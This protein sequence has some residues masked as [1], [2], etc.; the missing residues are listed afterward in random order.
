MPRVWSIGESRRRCQGPTTPPHRPWPASAFSPAWRTAVRPTVFA[1]EPHVALPCPGCPGPSH[2]TPWPSPGHDS[3]LQCPPVLCL[4]SRPK[5]H[6][7]QP[8]LEH[9]TRLFLRTLALT[10]PFLRLDPNVAFGG[11]L[12]RPPYLMP[13]ANRHPQWL[14]LLPCMAFLHFYL[15]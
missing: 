4:A 14:Y 9:G 11:G 2:L 15:L 5:M 8:H 1:C 10:V 6:P 12:S 13:V 7:R 3:H